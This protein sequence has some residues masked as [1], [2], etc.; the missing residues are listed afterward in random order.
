[1]QRELRNRL[2]KLIIILFVKV[3]YE[4]R[5]FSQIE[6]GIKTKTLFGKQK[7][8]VDVKLFFN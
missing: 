4:T 2:R 5:N 3:S 8:R 1:M 7:R 6:T